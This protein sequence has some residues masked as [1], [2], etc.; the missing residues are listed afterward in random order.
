MAT[1]NLVF[2]LYLLI[3]LTV[4][5]LVKKMNLGDWKYLVGGLLLTGFGGAMAIFGSSLR[6]L[7]QRFLD[8]TNPEFQSAKHAATA[9]G[10]WELV[11]SVAIIGKGYPFL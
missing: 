11:F 7:I 2:G 4:M 9:L 5:I 1:I 8:P 6:P 3:C 10:I